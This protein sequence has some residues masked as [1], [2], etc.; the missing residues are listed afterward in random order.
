MTLINSIVLCELLKELSTE[1]TPKTLP[2]LLAFEPGDTNGNRILYGEKKKDKHIA[3]WPDHKKWYKSATALIEDT[4]CSAYYRT[5]AAKEGLQT[6]MDCCPSDVN[7]ISSLSAQFIKV[8]NTVCEKEY[9][10]NTESFKKVILA[11]LKKFDVLEESIRHIEELGSHKEISQYLVNLAQNNKGKPVPKVTEMRSKKSDESP[12]QKNSTDT[13]QTSSQQSRPILGADSVQYLTYFDLQHYGLSALDLAKQLIAND[14]ALFGDIGEHAGTA[15]Q[16]AQHIRTTPENWGFLCLGDKI[17]GNW[18]C[19]FLTSDQEAAIRAGSMLG[20]NFTADCAANPLSSDDGEVAVHL[21][22][23]SINEGYQTEKHWSML[24]T[25]FGERLHQL[26]L[27][28]VFYRSISTC[29]FSKDYEAIFRKWGFDYL[30]SRVGRGEIYWMDLTY[31]IPGAFQRILPDTSLSELYEAHWGAP[32]TFRQLSN[33]DCK[34]LSP[35]QLLDISTLIVGTDRYIYEEAM[36]TRAQAKRILPLVFSSKKDVMFNLDNLFVAE[37]RGRIIGLILHKKGRLDW[38]AQ[39]VK[40]MAE[41][42][43]EKLSESIDQVETKYFTR[44]NIDG[45][46]RSII[47][48]SVNTNWCTRD[49]QVGKD[50][51]SAFVECY[52]T[53]RLW[54]YVLQETLLEM[55]VYLDSDFAFEDLCNGWSKDDRDLPCAILVRPADCK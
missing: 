55:Q 40:K 35:Q 28:G 7:D 18:S 36:M 48:F 27:K 42:Q 53:D 15:E 16:W 30:T 20:N 13:S 41:S 46:T 19:T 17:I 25:T 29:A 52:G 44:Y 50:L 5:T 10:K 8:F 1:V 54:L 14:K 38:S 23:I 37:A 32:I 45:D 6:L 2:Y 49:I 43:G 3:H 51:M 11:T 47:N 4:T 9:E 33:K 12:K 34:K 31:G 22:N 21:L 39:Y 24:W 26:A